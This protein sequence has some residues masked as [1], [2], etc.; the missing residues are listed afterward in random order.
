MLID[1][2]WPI[3][4]CIALQ[5]RACRD[6]NSWLIELPA[7]A[8]AGVVR[9]RGCFSC[10]PHAARNLQPANECKNAQTHTHTASG[11]VVGQP[12]RRIKTACLSFSR[13][14][15][16]IFSPCLQS[17]AF[18]QSLHLL[19]FYVPSLFPSAGSVRAALLPYIFAQFSHSKLA[20][21][22][23]RHDVRV[24]RSMNE[25]RGEAQSHERKMKKKKK[26]PHSLLTEFLCLLH[27]NAISFRGYANSSYLFFAFPTLYNSTCLNAAYVAI[28]VSVRFNFDILSPIE[29]CS[30]FTTFFLLGLIT[31]VFLSK[32]K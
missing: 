21:P 18:V 14:H 26:Q 1:Q 24:R 28:F 2:I 6:R 4:H 13:L 17:T 11:S 31:I 29:N 25:T 22:I 23:G 7:A 30:S 9:P 15:N 16:N 19:L 32:C 8:A 27:I 3:S 5:A 12:S 10:V 20:N